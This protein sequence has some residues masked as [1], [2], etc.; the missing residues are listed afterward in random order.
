M[1]TTNLLN[2]WQL[3]ATKIIL[4]VL[5]SFF[6]FVPHLMGALLVMLAG[7]VFAGWI[8]TLSLKI[9]TLA[10]LDNLAKDKRIKVI[11]KEINISRLGE[12]LSSLIRWLTLLVF[13]IAAL[14]ILGLNTI[15]TLLLGILNYVPNIVSAIIVLSLGVLLAG[16]LESVVKGTLISL[17][18]H[19]ARLMGR[20]TSY[21]TI[22]LTILIAISELDIAQN[23]INI[24]LIGFVFTLSLGFGLAL[25]LGS[26]DLVAKILT[27]WYKNLK[28]QTSPSKNQ[29]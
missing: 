2:S 10:H 1:Q 4:D 3:T 29:R 14:N 19:T 17:D 24:L 20:I 13:F 25:G 15:S 22:V 8:K 28:K 21:L 26:K 7:I 5:N 12:A 18:L 6:N 16:F 11:L 23:F 27:D 9:F